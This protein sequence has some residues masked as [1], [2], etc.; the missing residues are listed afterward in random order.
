MGNWL[1]RNTRA[2][3]YQADTA[4]VADFSCLRDKKSFFI[5]WELGSGL[6]LIASLS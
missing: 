2:E 3:E 6:F 4:V 1:C 5:C